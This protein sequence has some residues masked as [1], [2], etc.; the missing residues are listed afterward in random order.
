MKINSDVDL[1]SL[2]SRISAVI[3]NGGL[4]TR[5]K[6]PTLAKALQVIGDKPI[7][8]W[9]I[10]ALRESG[11]NRFIFSLGNLSEQILSWANG[12]DWGTSEVEF[13]IDDE[14]KGTSNALIQIRHLIDSEY[15][16]ICMGDVMF[17]QSLAVEISQIRSEFSFFPITHPNNHPKTSDKLFMGDQ[18]KIVF[19][20]KGKDVSESSSY[21]NLCL[22]GI[23]IVRADYLIKH[24]FVDSNFEKSLIPDAILQDRLLPLESFN[25]F[26]DSG[27]SESI[28]SIQMDLENGL[29]EK[30]WIECFLIDLDE[31]LIPDSISDKK[32]SSM[33]FYPDSLRFI[34]ECNRVNIKLLVVTNQPALAKGQLTRQE[35]NAFI[36]NCERYLSE[37][38]IYWDAFL[39]CPHHPE[40]GHSGE[41]TE[42]KIECLCRKP[43]VGLIQD[44]VQ[45]YGEKLKILGMAGDSM[46]DLEFSINA[47]V[48]FFHIRRG[49]PCKISSKSHKCMNS[50]DDLGF[51]N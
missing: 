50:L 8:E 20:P 3:L 27:T 29:L 44:I 13:Y 4:G 34:R 18:G 33:N 31:T 47:N 49:E 10:Q 22:T 26:K 51:Q 40:S 23:S 12:F 11:V 37:V 35:L 17:F 30:D 7:I 9:Q 41:V 24:N 32:N 6:D 25:Y 19:L 38:K 42:L 1:E 2:D 5:S 16:I 21:R 15:V 46:R 39:Y 28:H 45:L 14:L 43:K 36:S 48:P